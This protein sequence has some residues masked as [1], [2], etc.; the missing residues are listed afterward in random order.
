M[1]HEAEPFHRR[2]D[3]RDIAGE[4]GRCGKPLVRV[5]ACVLASLLPSTG[6]DVADLEIFEILMGISDRRIPQRFKTPL[7]IEEIEIYGTP[8]EVATLVET[9]DLD[10]KSEKRLAPMPRHE[11]LALMT[12]KG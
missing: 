8:A 10:G 5:R 9:I 1:D 6:D 7:S 2:A 12:A 4:G 3:H 11:R